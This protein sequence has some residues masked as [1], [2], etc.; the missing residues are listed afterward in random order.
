MHKSLSYGKSVSQSSVRFGD[1]PEKAVDGKRDNIVRRHFCSQTGLDNPAWWQVDLAGVY[2]VKTISI[3]P[4]ADCTSCGKLNN[5][6]Y[7]SIRQLNYNTLINNGN[8]WNKKLSCRD[9]LIVQRKIRF[10]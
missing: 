7:I 2:V 8:D 9:V 3:T 6:H 4:S 10:P 5:F 1:G